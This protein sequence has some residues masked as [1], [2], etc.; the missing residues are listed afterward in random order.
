MELVVTLDNWMEGS[1][2]TYDPRRDVSLVDFVAS[3]DERGALVFGVAIFLTK[4]FDPKNPNDLSFSVTEDSELRVEIE[5]LETRL[6]SF[7]SR[8]VAF[9]S[10][11]SFLDS[12]PGSVQTTS[13]I[14][15]VSGRRLVRP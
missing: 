11:C 7:C 12:R 9:L 1:S 8:S 2:S 3:S 4:L 5:L 6:L 10:L 15:S 14:I 13:H